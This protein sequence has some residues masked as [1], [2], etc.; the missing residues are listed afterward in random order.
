[1][2]HCGF[3]FP[4]LRLH[5]SESRRGSLILDHYTIHTADLKRSR[6]FYA[7]ILGLEDGYRPPFEGPPGA[8][9]YASHGHP[10]VHLYAGRDA[11][12]PTSNALDHIAF[13]VNEIDRIL[14]RLDAHQINYDTATVPDLESKQIFFLDP[15]GIQVE[16]NYD[17][18]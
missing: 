9:L 12:E 14:S 18:V 5:S 17:P 15:D 7:E 1:M 10:V 13:R 11:D 16:L 6:W 2:G 3:P 8:W 4:I